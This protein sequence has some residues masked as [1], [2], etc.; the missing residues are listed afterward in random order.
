[1]MQASFKPTKQLEMYFRYKAELKY[2]NDDVGGQTLIPL[3]TQSRKSWR[4]HLSYRINSIFT[5]RTRAEVVWFG[6]KEPTREEGFL[7]YLDLFYKPIRK[8]LSGNLRLQYF[9]TDGYSSR[10]YAYEN[11]L[12]YSYSIP[13]FY[14]KG[15]RYYFN[16][17]H[18][19]GKKISLWAKWAQFIYKEKSFI[20]TGLDEIQASHKSEL[21]LQLMYKF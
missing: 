3:T 16:I 6:K 2:I 1:M 15:Y 20:G 12:L 19:L 8:I 7:L 4:T 18:D 17:N 11:D 9:E 5:L 21:K 14:D 13:V 10:L